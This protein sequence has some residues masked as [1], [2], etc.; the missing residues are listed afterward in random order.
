MAPPFPANLDM[1]TIQEKMSCTLVLNDDEE[2][3]YRVRLKFQITGQGI[4]IQTKDDFNPLPILLDY[5][6]PTTLSGFDL[7]E[8]FNPNNLIFEGINQEQ[9][10]Q[11]GGVLP[12]GVYTICVGAFD[13]TRFEQAGVSNPSCMVLTLE[14]MDPPRIISPIG[15]QESSV[16]QNLLFQWQPMHI[17]GILV[18]YTLR[19][20]ELQPNLTPDLTIT[21]EA[22]VFEHSVVQTLAYVYDAG[23]P[24]LIVGQ[25]YIVTVQVQPMTGTGSFKNNGVSAYEVFTYGEECMQSEIAELTASGEDKTIEVSWSPVVGGE[26]LILYKNADVEDAN[27]YEDVASEQPHTIEGLEAGFSYLVKVGNFCHD[28]TVLYSAEDSVFLAI[29]ED[30]YWECGLAVDSLVFDNTAPLEMLKEGDEVMAGDFKVA[31]TQVSGSNGTFYGNGYI[32]VPYFK[33]ARV[34]VKFVEGITVNTDYQ[35]IG[36]EM[37]VTGGGIDLLSDNAIIVLDLLLSTLD[38]IDEILATKEEL[39]NAIDMLI[40]EMEP[41]LP[42]D[43]IQDLLDAQSAFEEAANALE[44]AQN[45]GGDTTAEEEK[46]ESAKEDLEAANQAYKEALQA[47]LQSFVDILKQ[48]FEELHTEYNPQLG[49]LEGSY[50][51]SKDSVGEIL[52]PIYAPFENVVVLESFEM[53]IETLFETEDKGE[54]LEAYPQATDYINVVDGYWDNAKDYRYAELLSGLKSQISLPDSVKIDDVTFMT[55]L[56]DFLDMLKAEHLDVLVFIGSRIKEEQET[57]AIVEELEEAL[58]NALERILLQTAFLTVE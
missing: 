36:G 3:N 23:A 53:E 8:Y 45:E 15:M 37:T 9:F 34:N 58:E 56:K 21:S 30:E 49:G 24:P 18:Q 10:M 11:S 14:D 28:N 39:L 52:D 38:T 43:V 46:L 50:S 57:D 29:P 42:D 22:P 51:S 13:Y 5:N 25:D 44:A 32:K 17:G 6:V 2:F 1:T 40:A 4:S 31:I 16:P 47:F 55:D 54:F 20:Y 48:T 41:Y 19:V 12:E 26:T 27:W 33:Q 7:V 35:M